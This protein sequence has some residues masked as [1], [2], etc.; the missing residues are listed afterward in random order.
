MNN[1]KL[2]FARRRN[3]SRR[4]TRSYGGA[5]ASS[6]VIQLE[7]LGREEPD[8]AGSWE[9]EEETWRRLQQVKALTSSLDNKR[10]ARCVLASTFVSLTCTGVLKFLP[11]VHDPS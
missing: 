2:L 6:E 5:A 1:S 4:R 3:A 9:D 11:K 8:G 10:K 7:E